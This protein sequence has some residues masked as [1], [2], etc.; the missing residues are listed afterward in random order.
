MMR[1][2]CPR[3]LK[4]LDCLH[5]LPHILD[6][7]NDKAVTRPKEVG[8][9]DSKTDAARLEKC[10]EPQELGVERAA[11][12]VGELIVIPGERP[13]KVTR[14]PVSVRVEQVVEVWS[15]FLHF[16]RLTT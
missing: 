12:A 8:T 15:D 5:Y 13:R 9:P 11:C 2:N 10:Q 6:R 7:C 1:G 16:I 4:L 14:G 3:L